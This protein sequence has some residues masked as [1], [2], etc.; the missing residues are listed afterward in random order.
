M[1]SHFSNPILIPFPFDCSGIDITCITSMRLSGKYK[2]KREGRVIDLFSRWPSL[3]PPT[4]LEKA[5]ET[6]RL[7]AGGREGR[8]TAK[9]A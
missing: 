5:Q 1:N 6:E 4:V 2:M 7:W 9:T 3:T 8:Q